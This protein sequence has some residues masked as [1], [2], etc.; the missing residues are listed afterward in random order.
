MLNKK[1]KK[2]IRDPNLFFSDMVLKQK[3]KYGHIYTK[4]VAGHYQY[5]VVSAVYNVGRYLDDYFK[6]LVN[7]KLDFKK[8]IHLVLV[9]DGSTDD[10][11]NIIKKWKAKYPDNIT[12]VWKENGGQASAR[13]LGIEFVNTKWVSFIDPDDFVD[14]Y[15]FYEIDNALFNKNDIKFISCNFIFYFEDINQYK[16]NHP[17]KY[18]FEKGDRFLNYLS[19]N[20]DIQLS[21]NSALF[22]MEIISQNNVRFNDNIKPNFE[23]AHFV[24]K[25]LYN[26]TNEKVAFLKKAKYFYRKRSDGTST[27]DTSWEKKGLYDTVLEHGCLNLL[28]DYAVKYGR[29]PDRMQI[30]VL[31]HLIWYIKKIVNNNHVISFL[32]DAEKDKFKSLMFDIFN[33]IDEKTIIE[34]NLGGAWFFHKVGL[35]G[36]YK[37]KDPS[38]QIAYISKYDHHKKMVQLRYF[39]RQETFQSVCLDGID[40]IPSYAKTISHT[41]ID[42]NFVLERRIW[43]YVGNAEKIALKIGNMNAKL[44]LGNNQNNNSLKIS[45]ISNYFKSLKPKYTIS[46]IYKDAWLFI[47]R[48]RYADDNAE[49]LYRYVQKNYPERKIYFVIKKNTSEWERLEKDNFNL[50][51]FASKDYEEALKSCDKVISSHANHYVTNYLGK[52]MLAGRHFVFLQHGITKDD[53]SEWLNKKENIDCFITATQSEYNSIAGNFNHYNYTKKEV[54]LTGFPRHDNL[55]K[56]KIKTERV[57]LIMPTWRQNAVGPVIGE[58]DERAINPNFLNTEFAKNWMDLIHSEKLKE[59]L[60]KYEFKA[61]FFPHSLIKPYIQQL[62]IPNY[63][64]VITD[65]SGSMQELFSRAAMIVTDYSSVAFEMAVQKKQAIY[66]QFDEDEVFS[67]GHTYAKGYFDYRKHG[68]GPVTKS[69][70][71]LLVMLDSILQADA[72]P[73]NHIIERIEKTFCCLDGNSCERAYS[74]INSLNEPYDIK[75]N[76]L[77]VIEEYVLQASKNEVW[78]IAELRIQTYLSLAN[79][80]KSELLLL[81]VKACRLQNKFRDAAYYLNL[82]K[83]IEGES[84]QLYFEEQA[85]ISMAMLRWDVAIKYWQLIKKDTIDNI[86]YGYCIANSCNEKYDILVNMDEDNFALALKYYIN[87]NW[88]LLYRL[89][90]IVKK[91]N[92]LL[93][94]NKYTKLLLLIANARRKGCFTKEAASCLDDITRFGNKDCFFVFE[95]IK[96]AFSIGKYEDVLKKFNYY[97]KEIEQLPLELLYYYVYSLMVF[98]KIKETLDFFNKI[99]LDNFSNENER[100]Y[101]AK[102]LVTLKKWDE[103]I[104]ILLSL[105]DRNYSVIYLIS[106]TFKQL[107]EYEK[108]FDTLSSCS[109]SFTAEGWKLKT[110]LAQLTD[111]WDLA[112]DCWLKYLR[113]VSN[114]L[115]E[116][117]MAV[118]QKLKLISQFQLR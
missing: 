9:D 115:T 104:V 54:V 55:I 47:D 101:Y 2:L 5:T 114:E 108:A 39:I 30:T 67:G 44:S 13:N 64:D 70:N 118:L 14:S 89:E 74:A 35:L 26:F 52:Q 25:Y 32:T 34:F 84:C 71:E 33:Y 69:L 113:S 61:I 15:Y 68:F 88:D 11:A 8:H 105:K 58:G 96:L 51:D 92:L 56:N 95:S 27:L 57:V 83:N 6:S 43:V 80:I 76:S 116:V 10:S 38:F 18:R 94:K 3:K 48:D 28:E 107:G 1:L 29:V 87:K 85:L 19:L 77:E 23:D 24:S 75:S 110:E 42:D 78:N 117:D 103:A 112:Y 65:Y 49:H 41:F 12:Y 21:V 97:F 102:I 99:K 40:T 45:T 106:F 79:Y 31:Y 72:I 82:F 91:E 66:F 86:E 7:Q 81:M 37:E 93:D 50:I 100:F 20:K 22:S 60:I 17:L 59:M 90:E 109:E 4:K 98:N 16:D 62:D 46:N 63:I 36:L 111:K 53:L 73:E